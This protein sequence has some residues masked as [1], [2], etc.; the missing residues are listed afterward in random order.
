M[1]R[2]RLISATIAVAVVTLCVCVVLSSR[3]VESAEETNR[4]RAKTKVTASVKKRAR[5]SVDE[6][7][8]SQ[9]DDIFKEVCWVYENDW[10]LLCAMAYHESRFRWDAVSSQGAQGIM[11]IMPRISEHF[12][13]SQNEIFE[14]E[15]NITV[16]N[17][18]VNSIDKMLRLPA[19]T[20]DR[21]RLSFILASYNG[22]IGYVFHA[23]KVAR[24]MG[25]NPYSWSDV[26]LSLKEMRDPDFAE[27]HEVRQFKGV[28]QTIAYVNNV[29]AHYYDYCEFASL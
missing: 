22:G 24:I 3:E 10:R 23:Q 19:S 14:V 2:K 8:I 18:L 28:Y 15:T 4:H 1:T 20:S 29:L 12:G 13:V 21:D 26:A 16:A 27:Q 17:M 5:N 11:Q 25:R 9:Y 7:A 6:P